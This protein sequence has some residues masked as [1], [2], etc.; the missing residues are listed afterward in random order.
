MTLLGLLKAVAS[1]WKQQQLAQNAEEI[2]QLG[3]ELYDRLAKMVDHIEDVGVNLR[4][5]GESYDRMIGS[6]EQKVLPGARRFKELGVASV[7]E[8][9]PVEPLRLAVRPIAKAELIRRGDERGGDS[10]PG[11]TPEMPE[12]HADTRT[13]GFTSIASIASV[14]RGD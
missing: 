3:R 8:I 10:G 14:D 11:D 13:G 4:Q 1:G 9:A 5:A 12:R 2:Q 6:L 7:K